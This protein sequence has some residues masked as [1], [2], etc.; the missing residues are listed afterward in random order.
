MAGVAI[1]RLD[2]SSVELRAAASREKN[3]AASRLDGHF[4]KSH[5]G[6]E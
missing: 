2:M 1:T 4:E 3:S 6:S 5:N